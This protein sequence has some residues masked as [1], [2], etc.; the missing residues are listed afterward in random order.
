VPAKAGASAREA[1]IEAD[2]S[3]KAVQPKK[4]EKESG[5]GGRIIFNF[6]NADLYEVI[7]TIADL[8]KINYIVDRGIKGR[9]TIHTAGGL[10]KRDL[11]PVFFQ[12][13]EA[14][15]LTAIEEGSLYKIVPLKDASRMPINS[16][17][18]LEGEKVPPSERIIIQ[19]IPLKFISAQE[20]TKLVT[21]FVST[22]GTIISEPKSNTL[23]VVDKW[24]NILKILRL[25][26]A[27]DVNVLERVYYRF[28]PLKY[29][30]AEDTV[31][32]MTDFMSAYQKVGNLV[33]KFIPI[34]GLNIL[35]VVSSTPLVFDKI[36]DIIR[37]IDVLDEEIAPRVYVYFVKNGEAKDLAELLDKVFLKKS[38]SRDKDKPRDKTRKAGGSATIAG[39]PLS[40]ARVKEKKVEKAAEAKTKETPRKSS[41]AAK[42]E[43]SGSGTLMGE[44]N[45]T[46]DEMRNAL[47]IEAIPSDHRII[48]DILRQ[49]DVLPRQVLIEATIAEVT[50][51]ASTELG[52]DWAF[53]KG[54][55]GAGAGS[56]LA[57]IGKT[58]LKYS[59]GV[60]DKWY[61]EL[62]ALAKKGLVNIISS[63]HVLASDNKE[64]RIDVSREIP[65]ASGQTT[66]ASGATVSE[67]TIEYRDTGVILS[68]TPHIND[69]GLVTMD[70]S[71]EVSDLDEDVN[72]AG[73]NYPS[74]FKRT[75]KTTLTVKHGQT[76]VI[77]G[78][79]K[80]KEEE[81]IS[82]VPCLIDI[83][84]VRYLFGEETKKTQKIELIV[85]IT[86]RVVVN[87]DDVDRVTEEF[88]Q[89]VKNVVKLFNK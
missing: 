7:K 56:F 39:N 62:N 49:I 15:G 22:G 61:A 71:Q 87:L 52:V 50:R 3:P 26:Q 88:K 67:T 72:V 51:T 8:L 66:V 78:L 5:K 55:A 32:A 83:P 57:T 13:L 11:F 89:K 1:A 69:R 25:V 23:L 48:E 80:D 33:V 16:R 45:I 37:Q 86:P 19:I 20:M 31:K 24:F 44:I 59:I 84:V 36:E 21:P 2:L 27:F 77:G 54:A 60:T 4:R 58:G 41:P 64:A 53:G 14:N 30:D 28:Y 65:V 10:S 74:F 81:D 34:T 75:V 35:F 68:V 6:D 29:L 73:K 46:P 43:P 76:I 79:I 9:V 70:I 42:G 47:I 63:P 82:G 40:A 17:F 85:L 38:P 12:I 18:G